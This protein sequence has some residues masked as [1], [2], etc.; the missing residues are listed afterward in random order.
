MWWF[1]DAPHQCA[2]QAAEC[3]PGRGMGSSSTAQQDQS[4]HSRSN[5]HMQ[6]I[7][8]RHLPNGSSGKACAALKIHDFPGSKQNL[9]PAPFLLTPFLLGKAHSVCG[10]RVTATPQD[11]AIKCQKMPC[12]A[13]REIDK[14]TADKGRKHLHK[15]QLILP[16]DP[17]VHTERHSNTSD[18][19]ILARWKSCLG[20]RGNRSECT[21]ASDCWLGLQDQA[22]SCLCTVLKQLVDHLQ[23]MLSVRTKP[24]PRAT[25]AKSTASSPYQHSSLC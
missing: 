10:C 13:R 7:R 21:S 20:N 22:V 5:I 23:G 3:S 15:I 18:S 6:I 1:E 24:K 16:E 2:H 12:P 17:K 4:N 11:L 8:E 25:P 9:Y 14:L 19:A